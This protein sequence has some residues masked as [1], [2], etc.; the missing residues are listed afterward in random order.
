MWLATRAEGAGGTMDPRGRAGAGDTGD[1]GDAGGAERGRLYES[2][3]VE[4]FSDGVLAIA[5]TLLVLDLS[6]RSSPGHVLADL[7]RQ[8]PAYAAYLASFGLIGVIWVNHHQMFNGIAAVDTGLLW[9]NLA[10]LL[11]V[12]VLPFPTAV[13]SNA[14]QHGNRFDEMAACIFYAL[15]VT[16]NSAAWLTLYHY[17][18]LNERLLTRRASVA[19][20]A[21]ERRRALLGMASYLL[22]ILIA[23]WEPVA[24]LVI[25][26][27]LP[28]FYGVTSEGWRG[29][30]RRR[31]PPPLS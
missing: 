1:D 11:T 4:A 21:G 12:S 14:F 5:I 7:L 24:S 29:L 27:A 3:R 23:L 9:R 10:L 22:A 30:R 13:L 6:S 31:R 2:A 19:F 8:W 15:A 17:L 26:C 18:S 16:L 28:V 25:L 20:F